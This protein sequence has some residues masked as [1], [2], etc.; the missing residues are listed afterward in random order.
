MRT[1]NNTNEKPKGK[2]INPNN[3][4]CSN[5]LQA[6]C[7]AETIAARYGIEINTLQDLRELIN[8]NPDFRKDC[9]ALNNNH[10]YPDNVISFAQ[11]RTYDECPVRFELPH[12]EQ[13]I[14]D[15][16]ERLQSPDGY[17]TVSKSRF[18][19]V[20]H[21]SDKDRKNLQVYI[22]HLVDMG[23]LKCIYK[24]PKGS[25]KP[26][27]YLINRNVTW[28]GKREKEYP[29]TVQTQGFEPKYTRVKKEMTLPDGS[30]VISGTLDEKKDSVRTTAPISKDSI[31]SSL[32]PSYSTELP[33]ENQPIVNNIPDF[34]EELTAD[35][36]A[37][38]EENRL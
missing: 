2:R 11:T 3:P 26:G 17:V 36:L 6:I 23:F 1:L 4:Y 14:L 12:P 22:D 28:I 18:V 9:D 31:E 29:V 38:F 15:L 19:E 20:L 24:P 8:K 25:K 7:D 32:C 34:S 10:K 13:I 37:I 27:E 21:L 33:E 5:I 35:E 16:M 30:K